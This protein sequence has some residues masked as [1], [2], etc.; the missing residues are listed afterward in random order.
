MLHNGVPELGGESFRHVSGMTRRTDGPSP[1]EWWLTDY[2]DVIDV[3]LGLEEAA[4]NWEQSA[5]LSPV[6]V[7]SF[8]TYA[9][10][11]GA[12]RGP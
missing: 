6:Q 3:R 7:E 10:D 2:G 12:R 5:S 9:I 1:R 4:T 8:R 11:E